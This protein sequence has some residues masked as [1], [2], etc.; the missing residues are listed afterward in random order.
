MRETEL[1]TL[2][3]NT[4]GNRGRLSVLQRRI[5]LA[6]ADQ[7]GLDVCLCEK[8]GETD[9]QDIACYLIWRHTRQREGSAVLLCSACEGRVPH[10]PVLSS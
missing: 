6:I 1:R 4:K 10:G 5:V 8:C 7:S 9:K 3:Q 2:V